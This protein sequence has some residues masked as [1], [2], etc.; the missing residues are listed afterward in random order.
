MPKTKQLV[1]KMN[2]LFKEVSS[3]SNIGRGGNKKKPLVM[4]ATTVPMVITRTTDIVL[5]LKKK[6]VDASEFV[7]LIIDESTSASTTAPVYCGI[8]GMYR[9]C[10]LVL[11]TF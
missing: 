10:L 1:N 8:L 6:H 3:T 7:G 5:K 9:I 4:H 11:K 2:V